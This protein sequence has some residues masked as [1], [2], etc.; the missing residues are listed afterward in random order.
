MIQVWDLWVRLFHWSLAASVG[1]LLISGETGVGFFD[2]HRLAG[3][4]VL[5][6]LAFRLL[7]GLL[8]SDNARLRSLVQH[9]KHALGH[10]RQVLRRDVP[11]ERGH[12]AAGGWAVLFMLGLVSLQALTGMFIADDEEWVSGAWYGVLPTDVSNTLYNIHHT[13]AELIKILVLVHIGMIVIYALYVGQNLVK[14]MITG[15]MRWDESRQAIPDVQFASVRK[16]CLMAAVVAVL[17]A[18]A[19]GWVP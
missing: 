6:L 4:V 5:A 17:V 7:W 9:P 11:Q 13:N 18:W 16:G 19:V 3:E 10:L 2:W 12:N 1:F 14:G 15:R 8:G